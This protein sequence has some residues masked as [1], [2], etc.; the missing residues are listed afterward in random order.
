MSTP[1]RSVF[2]HIEKIFHINYA[3]GKEAFEIQRIL[4]IN[5]ILNKEEKQ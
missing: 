1:F 5:R 2:L 4:P 3:T